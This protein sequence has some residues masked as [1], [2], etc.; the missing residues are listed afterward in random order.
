MAVCAASN[1]VALR[2]LTTRNS[3]AVAGRPTRSLVIR[4]A[5]EPRQQVIQPVNGDP[6]VGMLETPVTSS[7]LVA[8]FLSNLPAYRTGVAP[9]LRGVEIGLVHGFLLPGPFIKF[10]PL[11]NID[12][13]AEIAGTLAAGGLVLILATALSIYGSAQFQS[14]PPLGVKTLSGRSIQ[15]D[16]LQSAEGWNEFTAGFTVGALSGVAWAYICTQI[17]PYYS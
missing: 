14:T 16:P 13:A 7:P 1:K 11:R 8:N 6:F 2:G 9:L 17:L 4:A 12:G 10:G 15:R 5:A 3:V